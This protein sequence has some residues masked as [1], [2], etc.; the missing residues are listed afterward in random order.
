MVFQ[1]YVIWY[2]HITAWHW[3]DPGKRLTMT[4]FMMTVTKSILSS[5]Q[6]SRDIRFRSNNVVCATSKGS[7]QP[8]HIRSLIRA[9][10]S[11]LNILWLLDYWLNIFLSFKLKRRL[12]RIVW[13]YTYQNVTLLKPRMSRLCHYFVVCIFVLYMLT[14]NSR[15]KPR[16][17]KSDW[18]ES[19]DDDFSVVVTA[20]CGSLPLAYRARTQRPVL[21]THLDFEEGDLAVARHY[22]TYLAYLLNRHRAGEIGYKLQYGRCHNVD[23]WW[24][25]MT[26][27]ITC[28]NLLLD[29]NGL[30]RW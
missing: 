26:S 8:V 23:T 3:F 22:P 4:E 6:L 30:T 10:V 5:K 12:Y 28:S 7:D 20:R 2:P 1:Y 24:R 17:V 29:P 19:D 9:F 18:V 16:S 15:A 13:V 11:R 21:C 25:T 14:N 27:Q